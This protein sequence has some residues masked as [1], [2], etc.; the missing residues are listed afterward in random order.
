MTQ[1]IAALAML[2]V[3]FPRE[4]IMLG[5]ITLRFPSLHKILVKKEKPS[6][7]DIMRTEA[8]QAQQKA[9]NSLQDSIDFLQV[10]ADSSKL[11][12]WFPQDRTDFFDPL[13]AAMEQAVPEGRVVRIVHY[14]DSQIE[15]DRMT[16][17]LRTY[18]QQHFGG[19]GPGMQ[20]SLQ[21]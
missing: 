6:L 7:E 9:L 15:S 16:Q 1:V 17:Q 2:C 13:F 20:P 5:D 14:G 8:Y 19:G 10:Q 21:P 11:R 3:F 12:F 4:G 18:M